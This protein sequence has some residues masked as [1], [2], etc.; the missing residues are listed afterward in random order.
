MFILFASAG[1]LSDSAFSLWVSLINVCKLVFNRNIN[2]VLLLYYEISGIFQSPDMLIY[3]LWLHN[4]Y[5]TKV[6]AGTA[7]EPKICQLQRTLV[8]VLKRVRLLTALVFAV[9]REKR[10]ETMILCRDQ[11]HKHA[12]FKINELE[13]HYRC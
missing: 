4:V 12:K 7:R 8:I 2:T 11:L 1:V 9:K 6:K 13:T 5:N 10:R 3:H